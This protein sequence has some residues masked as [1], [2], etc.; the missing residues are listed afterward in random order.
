LAWFCETQV[1]IKTKYRIP[2]KIDVNI[3]G[4]NIKKEF[5]TKLGLDLKGGSNL[6]FKLIPQKLNGKI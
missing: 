6:I 5:N 3:F 4:L 2:D 1:N